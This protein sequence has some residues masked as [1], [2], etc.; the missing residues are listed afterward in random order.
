MIYFNFNNK[1]SV[2]DKHLMS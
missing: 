1:D 2:K